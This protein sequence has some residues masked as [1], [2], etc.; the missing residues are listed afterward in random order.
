[1]LLLTMQNNSTKWWYLIILAL[2]WGSS[3]ILIKKSLI[4]LTPIQLGAFRVFIAGLFLIAIGFKHLKA[5]KKHH[6]KWLITAG[7]IGTFFPAFC[8]AYAQTEIDSAITSILNA[9]TPIMTL[10]FGLLLFKVGFTKRQ[11]LGVLIGLAGCFLL[12][13]QGAEINTHQDYRYVFFI[14]IA[15][16]GYAMNVNILKSRLED[17]PAITIST[18]SFL[19]ITIP[20]FVIL[21]FSGFFTE[22]NFSDT[23]V[24]LSIGAASIL[25]I[26]SSALALLLFNKLIK[27]TTAVFSA[28]VTYLIPVVALA[29]GV[30]D[31]EKFMPSQIIAAFIILFGVIL[32]NTNKRRIRPM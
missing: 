18:A 30:F 8:F 9:T 20:A 21:L 2:V 31:G 27:M 25:A 10:L 7:F 26:C 11:I 17:L 14:F 29:W 12:I 13:W 3:F 32:S 24:L 5:I 28:S 23:T 16:W 15:T 4:A 19:A 6:I 1:M 22:L